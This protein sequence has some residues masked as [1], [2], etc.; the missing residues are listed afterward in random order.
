VTELE[1][2]EVA[3]QVETGSQLIDVRPAGVGGGEH[4]AGDRHIE[5]DQLSERG[6]EVDRDTSVVFYCQTG[7]RSQMA[8]EAFR[9]EGQD[10]YHLAGGIE[11]WKAAGLPVEHDG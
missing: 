7:K 8:A 6:G 2:Q 1:P 3:R 5:F 9:G 11:A 4:I 10:A